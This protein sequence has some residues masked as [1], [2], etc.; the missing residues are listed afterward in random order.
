MLTGTSLQINL[1]CHAKKSVCPLCCFDTTRPP[2]SQTVCC[3]LLRL[4][5]C[6]LPRPAWAS[7]LACVLPT[8]P[9]CLA[10]GAARVFTAPSNTYRPANTPTLPCATSTLPWL[11][12]Q[13]ASANPTVIPQ[14]RAAAQPSQPPLLRHSQSS[15]MQCR[16]TPSRLAGDGL[17]LPRHSQ[18]PQQ[19][20][21]HTGVPQRDLP[22]FRR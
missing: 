10:R 13:A 20:T 4:A 11:P 1:F 14:Q 16:N 3:K 17:V 22:Q 7:T 5:Q 15:H 19:A 9:V 18:R 12:S 8:L 2:P 6:P 21:F